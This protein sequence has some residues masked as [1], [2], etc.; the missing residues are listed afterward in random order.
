MQTQDSYFQLTFIL[1]DLTLIPILLH[2]ANTRLLKYFIVQD[3]I[4]LTI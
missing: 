3:I 4:K 1:L 2:Y